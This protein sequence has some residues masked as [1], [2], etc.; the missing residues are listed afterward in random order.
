[1]TS[2]ISPFLALIIIYVLLGLGI[3]GISLLTFNFV[4]GDSP[5][6]GRHIYI[7]LFFA[8][9]GFFGFLGSVSGGF[10]YDWLRMMPEWIMI[11]GF[12]VSGGIIMIFLAFFVAPRFL[13]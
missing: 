4:I 13:K 9:T 8:T 3:S 12:N 7:A 5:K 10:I 6:L 11:Y 2:I 1:L